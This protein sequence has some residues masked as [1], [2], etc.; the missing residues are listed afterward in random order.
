MPISRKQAATLFKGKYEADVPY[1]TFTKEDYTRLAGRIPEIMIG[2]AKKHGWCSF[3]GQ[4]LW[5]C[6]PDDW[7]ECSG[8]SGSPAAAPTSYS[9]LPSA[10]WW[11]W[12][13]G[14]FG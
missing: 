6:D 11:R 3:S 10:R 12:R 4:Q 7:Q 8:A 1:R 5:L 9:G 13:M 14:S 2:L